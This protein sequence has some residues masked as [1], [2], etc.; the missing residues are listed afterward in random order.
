M[1]DLLILNGRIVSGT[2]N[3]WFFGDVAVVKDKIVQLLVIK[4]KAWHDGCRFLMAMAI[5]IYFF[6]LIRRTNLKS[7]RV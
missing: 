1:Y 2:G 6:S 4:K 3:P 7:C 5:P